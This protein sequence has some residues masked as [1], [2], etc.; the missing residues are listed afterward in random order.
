M[1]T[2]K[3][4]LAER[5]IVVNVGDILDPVRLGM[6][7]NALYGPLPVVRVTKAEEGR[8]IEG[9]ITCQSCPTEFVLHVGDWFQ[10]RRCPKCQKRAQRKNSKPIVTAE[11]QADREAFK[12]AAAA[13]K[14]QEK[15]EARDLKI[16]KKAEKVRAKAEEKA[17]KIRADAEAKL[18][19]LAVKSA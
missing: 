2:P 3:Q 17:Q 8:L 12:A 9:I 13:I 7:P 1:A 16:A 6:E 10:K 18:A 14:A 15:A 5:K 19:K 11:E 4:F